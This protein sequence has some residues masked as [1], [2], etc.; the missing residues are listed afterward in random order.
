MTTALKVTLSGAT[1]DVTDADADLG[2]SGV[3]GIGAI[4]PI[5]AARRSD[6]DNELLRG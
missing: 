1:P 6:S 4:C 2:H 5:A 3:G